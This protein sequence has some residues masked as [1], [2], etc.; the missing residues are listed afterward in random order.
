MTQKTYDAIVVGGGVLGAAA[1]YHLARAGARAL[2]IDRHDPGRASDAGAGI[3]APEINRRDPEAWFHFAVPAVDYYP[4]LVAQLAETAGPDYDTG[5][6][7]CGSLLVAATPDEIP[8]FEV[9]QSEILTRREQRGTPSPDDL[10][11]ISGQEARELFPALGHVHRALYYRKGARVDG[12]LLGAALHR[13]AEVH[14]LAHMHAAVTALVRE[15]GRVT[16]VRVGDQV[17]GAGTVIIAGGAWSADFGAQLGVE[18]PIVPQRGQIA[19]LAL[20]G[21]RTGDWP[22]V[23]AF[24]GHYLVAWPNGRI[25]AGATREVGSGFEPVTS[26][27]GIQ[28]VLREAVRVAPGLEPAQ[29][30]E[31]RVGLRP[32]PP[33]GLPVVGEVP[34]VDGVLLATGHGPTGLQMGPYTGKLMAEMAMG[35]PPATPIDAFSI[36]RFG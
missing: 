7:R 35:Q 32:M 1:G 10:K 3:L 31:V 33:D 24:H 4:D 28:E 2:L 27:R 22:V 11:L 20:P 8:D 19:H 12:R 6:A 26:V 14:G 23:N 5:Y 21:Q 29:L 15:G 34:G 30:L 17:I 18:I 9:S 16:G 25:V 36:T 13:A